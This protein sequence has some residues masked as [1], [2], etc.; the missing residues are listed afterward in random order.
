MELRLV[1]QAFLTFFRGV[2]FLMT[3]N[4]KASDFK[5]DQSFLS[6][7]NVCCLILSLLFNAFKIEDGS[8]SRTVSY[9]HL[10]LPTKA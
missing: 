4:K 10:T 1:S 5:G 3:G 9:T 2:Y 8:P 7:V 6:F